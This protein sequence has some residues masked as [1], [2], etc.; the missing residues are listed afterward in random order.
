MW[1]VQLTLAGTFDR[2]DTTS[3]SPFDANGHF[4]KFKSYSS[5]D[6]K[7]RLDQGHAGGG[8]TQ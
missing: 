6:P 8:G 7:N 2:G 5:L 1:D 3:Y 4:D